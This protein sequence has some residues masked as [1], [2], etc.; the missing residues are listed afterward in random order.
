LLSGNETFPGVQ[1]LATAYA[2]HQFGH[3][4]PQL[5]DGRALLLG[6]VAAQD[7]VRREVQLKGAGRT[8]YSR[9]GDGRSALGPAI[10]EFLASEAM[11]AL[12]IPTTRALAVTL[13]GDQVYRD[14]AVP[15]AVFTRIARSHIRVGTFQ[16][17]A[18]HGGVADIRMLADHVIE[19]F[20][21]AI[22]NEPQPYRALFL[23]I[24][25]A[26][27]SLIARWMQI[28]FIHGVM[29]TDNMSVLGDTIDYGPCAFMDDYDP[30][31]VYSAIDQD[32]RYAYANQPSIAAW[33]L[34]RLAE[35]LLDL[36]DA[37]SEKAIAW[38]QEALRGFMPV[39]RE[40]WL[41]GMKSKIGLATDHPE[42]HL[43]IGQLLEAMQTG[44]A[45]F[46]LT[47]RRLATAIESGAESSVTSLFR[48]PGI[49]ERWLALWRERL[50]LESNQTEIAAQM[51]RVNPAFILRNHRVEWAIDAA[52]NQGDFS[53]AIELQTVLARPFDDQ[54]DFAA[55]QD[56]P[57]PGDWK[58]QTFCGT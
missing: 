16:Y 35:T 24:R 51:Q 8:P 45:D 27:A 30:A 13:T 48:A 42:D 1:P 57:Q 40:Y 39:Y 22:R 26:Q 54:P 49:V 36:I 11:H 28:G 12:G 23:A 37:D 46:T 17:M 29:N 56:P 3:F 47:F 25:D 5:G 33:N 6:E 44:H 50:K 19:H 9:G 38:A 32:G 21:P 14:R 55:Y 2:G 34:A 41:R 7:G 31:T 15:G 58:C 53:K 20:Y 4:V 52:V 18:A 43:L 10:R